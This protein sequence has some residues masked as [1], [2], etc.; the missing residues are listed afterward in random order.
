MLLCYFINTYNDFLLCHLMY[1][2][3]YIKFNFKPKRSKIKLPLVLEYY[4]KENNQL[5]QNH[6]LTF[7][8]N[9]Y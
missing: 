9:P 1:L 3:N 8:A 7:V 2:Y 5:I 4:Y 6:Q